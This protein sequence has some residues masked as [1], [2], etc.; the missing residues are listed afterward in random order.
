MHSTYLGDQLFRT[1]KAGSKN[2]V[3]AAALLM[4][5]MGQA[6]VGSIRQ[7]LDL[8]QFGVQTGV[9]LLPVSIVQTGEPSAERPG[10]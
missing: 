6:Q 2:L 8:A 7:N 9:P 3:L 10:A 1:V 5:H 4:P